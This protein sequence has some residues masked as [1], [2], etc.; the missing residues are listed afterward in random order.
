MF[1]GGTHRREATPQIPSAHSCSVRDPRQQHPLLVA[2]FSQEPIG[3]MRVT[4]GCVYVTAP[5]EWLPWHCRGLATVTAAPHDFSAAGQSAPVVAII[6][7]TH[8]T[9][10]CVVWVISTALPSLHS[11]HFLLAAPAPASGCT[12]CFCKLFLL[13]GFD[14]H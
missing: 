10:C 12:F 5:C 4:T 9:G 8:Y 7:Y 1:S 2:A 11:F 6:H 14:G 3:K 13:S